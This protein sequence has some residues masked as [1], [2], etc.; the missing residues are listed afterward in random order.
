MDNELCINTI[1]TNVQPGW[2]QLDGWNDGPPDLH[3]NT[4]AKQRE[5]MQDN[6]HA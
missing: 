2:L 1:S 5:A 4:G 6:K 3:L